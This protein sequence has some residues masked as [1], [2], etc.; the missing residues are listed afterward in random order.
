ME[1]KDRNKISEG[2]EFIED[3]FQEIGIK[4]ETQKK[5]S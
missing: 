1:K 2:E 5:N 3:F 4:Y